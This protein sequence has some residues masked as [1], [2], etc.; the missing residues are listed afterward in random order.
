MTIPVSRPDCRHSQDSGPEGFPRSAAGEPGLQ[1]GVTAPGVIERSDFLG[2][3]G[4]M[5]EIAIHMEF[6]M[7][8]YPIKPLHKWRFIAGEKSHRLLVD[9][10]AMFDG[11]GWFDYWMLLF[12]FWGGGNT[13]V[14]LSVSPYTSP[15]NYASGESFQTRQFLTKWR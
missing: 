9:F 3:H 2:N 1:R 13:F 5:H 15:V 10:P 12:F 11:S 7:G 8:S 14:F 4:K 6:S